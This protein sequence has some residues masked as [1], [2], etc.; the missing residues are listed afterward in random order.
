M[1]FC[2][3]CGKP[4]PAAGT[5]CPSCGAAVSGATGAP[6]PSPPPTYF[7]PGAVPPAG[8]GRAYATPFGPTSASQSA[9]RNA[10]GFAGWASVLFLISGIVG[11]AFEFGSGFTRLVS[12]TSTPTGTTISLPSPWIWVGYVGVLAGIDLATLVLLRESFRSLV[13]VDPRFS[14]PATFALVALFG[15]V[16]GLAGAGLLLAGLYQAVSCVGSGNPLTGACLFSGLFVGGLVLAVVGG[17]AALVGFIGILIGIWR[18]GTRYDESLF[19]VAAILLIFP[20]LNIIGA[21]LMLVAAR[22]GRQRVERTVGPPPSLV[23]G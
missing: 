9:D 1:S 19:K 21:I 16:I 3:F 11:V 10:L 5:F 13:P 7:A 22:S 8:Y 18:L 20:F 2:S 6:G 23:A 12:A 14:S 17:I 4:L 15:S